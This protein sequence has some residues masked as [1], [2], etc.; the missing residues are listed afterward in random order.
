[1]LDLHTD[2]PTGDT[3]DVRHSLLWII[4]E[5]AELRGFNWAEFDPA[6]P[7]TFVD[8]MANMLVLHAKFHRQKGHGMHAVT[9]PV[10]IFQAMPRIPGFVFT[11]D[12]LTATA[13]PLLP[14][15]AVSQPLAITNQ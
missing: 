2:Q 4:C 9:F 14:L 13:P 5:L 15:A 1:M 8:S 10:W 12:E 6:V 7:E 11:A 3:Y